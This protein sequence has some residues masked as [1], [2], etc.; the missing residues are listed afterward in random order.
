MLTRSGAFVSL[1]KR[2]R[3]GCIGLI[4]PRKTP[5]ENRRGNGRRLGVPGSPVSAAAEGRVA[6][7]QVE[8]SV[9]TPCAGLS[10][11]TRSRSAFTV[12]TSAGRTGGGLLLPQVATSGGGTGTPS[13]KRPVAKAGLAP[14]PGAIRR[15]RS[16]CLRPTCLLKNRQ[17]AKGWGKEG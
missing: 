14:L 16:I 6:G 3:R 1:K 7:P 9:L 5:G 4:E 2:G 8:I 12:F 17:R 13:W 15:R 10:T 11:L